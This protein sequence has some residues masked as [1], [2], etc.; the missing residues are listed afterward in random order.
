M[1]RK[2]HEKWYKASV[3]EFLEILITHSLQSKVFV[4]NSGESKIEA[5]CLILIPTVVRKFSIYNVKKTPRF[6]FFICQFPW[7]KPRLCNLRSGKTSNLSIQQPNYIGAIS[8]KW[9]FRYATITSA[10]FF[11]DM[12]LVKSVSHA[13][14]RLSILHTYI[15]YYVDCS[16]HL[17]HII[18]INTEEEKQYKEYDVLYL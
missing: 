2:V 12:S 5:N 10:S 9:I 18:R 1:Q 7:Q 4:K 11:L 17:L 16:A 15:W 3:F 14:K 8:I 6:H 13:L